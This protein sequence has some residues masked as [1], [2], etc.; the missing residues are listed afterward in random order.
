VTDIDDAYLAERERLANAATPGP[1][2]PAKAYDS[3]AWPCILGGGWQVA[4]CHAHLFGDEDFDNA[5]FIADA[6]TAVPALVAAVRRLREKI[7]RLRGIL[8][9]TAQATA[10]ATSAQLGAALGAVDGEHERLRAENAAIQR[11]NKELNRLIDD[12]IRGRMGP[13]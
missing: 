3:A 2:M 6:R 7:D 8:K 13:A 1:W 4:E 9:A 12:E 5:A 10:Q 11:A